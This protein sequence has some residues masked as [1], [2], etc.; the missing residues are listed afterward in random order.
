MRRVEVSNF[1]NDPRMAPICFFLKWTTTYIK[2]MNTNQWKGIEIASHFK[3][4]TKRKANVE[5]CLLF[6]RHLEALRVNLW[7]NNNF[8]LL[9]FESCH[10]MPTLFWT[11]LHQPPCGL[12]QLWKFSWIVSGML[13]V[14]TCSKWP[15]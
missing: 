1:V 4:L 10:A 11:P 14:F 8:S 13:K 6:N 3:L 15:S 9:L 2:K 7:N 12:V 5:Q